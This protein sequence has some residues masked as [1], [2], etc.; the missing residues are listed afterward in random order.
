MQRNVGQSV[1]W[2][3]E[4]YKLSILYSPPRC[5]WTGG[6][7]SAVAVLVTAG[8]VARRNIRLGRGDVKA[9]W[10]VA[11]VVFAAGVLSWALTATLRR[12]PP[13]ASLAP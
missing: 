12:E 6:P 4:A 1:P 5:S 3:L 13:S 11:A 9:A 10:R 7:R 8:L 2:E